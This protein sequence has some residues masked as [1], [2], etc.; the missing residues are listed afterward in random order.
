MPEQKKDKSLDDR[1]KEVEIKKIIVE[2]NKLELERKGLERQKKR[3][4]FTRRLF[5][6]PLIAG[7]V[8]VPL[9]WFYIRD[10]AIPLSRRENI[11]LIKENNATRDSLNVATTRFKTE[12]EAADRQHLNKLN[13][14]RNEYVRLDSI[15]KSLAEEY[16]KLTTQHAFTQ[17][18]RD[19]FQ[20]KVASLEKESE[21]QKLLVSGL[22]AQIAKAK[23]GLDFFSENAVTRMLI[24][25]KFF[26]LRRN[27][28]GTGI[29]HQYKPKTFNGDKVII[30]HATGLTWQ[31]SGSTGLMHYSAA[32]AYIQKLRSQPFAGFNDW[33]LPTLE[34]AMSLMEPKKGGPGQLYTDRIF[35]EKQ[36]FIWTAD[37]A[38]ASR[39]WIVYFFSGICYYYDI[40]NGYGYVRAV[41]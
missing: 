6:Q 17:K 20:M 31:Q 24:E 4:W 23:K 10:I 13:L 29:N 18:Q 27:K 11:R 8:A 28:D 34:E 9:L 7:I 41:R 32:E 37:K 21:A 14:S 3:S 15:R 5:L 1:L 40:G 25:N 26:D 30:D 39:A 33:R 12:K 2:T 38:T 36:I 16:Q 22:D 35:D 19:D